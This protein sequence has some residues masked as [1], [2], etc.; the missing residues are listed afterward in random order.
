MAVTA[1]IGSGT[2]LALVNL[3][4][5][6]LIQAILAFTAGASSPNEL[7][8]VVKQYCQYL[9]YIGLA[10]WACVYIYS[11]VSTYVAYRVVRNIR[12]DFFRSALSQDIEFF[13]KNTN[14]VSMQAT[15]NG[16]LIQSGVSEKLMVV[17]QALATCV[18]AFIIAFIIQWKLTLILLFVAPLMFVLMGTVASLESKIET[19]QLDLFAQAGTFTEHVLA[20]IRTVHAFGIRPRLVADFDVYIDKAKQLGMKKGPLYGFLFSLEYFIVYSATGLA[21]WQGIKMI[22]NGEV[23]DLGTVFTY[24]VLCVSFCCGLF[25]C[26]DRF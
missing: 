19:E 3:V 5:G 12:R 6:R 17:F 10:R 9:V 2:G 23:D 24:V 22:A 4:M 11:V 7:M 18:A 1:A 20:T 16:S 26:T 25:T 13:D 21:F 14:S 8:Q 15:T